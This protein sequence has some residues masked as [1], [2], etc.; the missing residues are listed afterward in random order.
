MNEVAFLVFMC[1][2]APAAAPS[3]KPV[4]AQVNQRD[5]DWLAAEALLLQSQT[6]SSSLTEEENK[7]L[8]TF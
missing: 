5:V 1:D 4:L 8:C 3:S 2:T 7:W 6:E